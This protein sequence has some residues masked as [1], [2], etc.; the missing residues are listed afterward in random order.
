MAGE[1]ITKGLPEGAARRA[2]R[3]LRVGAS[4]DFDFVVGRRLPLRG[5]GR[6]EP[7]AIGRRLRLSFEELGPNFVELGRFVS[8]RGDLLPPGVV[9]ELR[10]ARP[11]V[12]PLTPESVRGVVEEEL[13]GPLER[14][15]PEFEETPVRSG[16]ATQSHRA[17]L[18]GDRPALVVVDRPGLR[19]DLLAMRPVADVA[20]RRLGERLPLDPTGIVADFAAHMNH[21]RDM[22]AAAQNARRLRELEGTGLRVPRSYR[23]YSTERVITFERPGV[24]AP[25]GGG[26]PEAG[27]ALIRLALLE[28]YSLADLVPERI[29]VDADGVLWLADPTEMLTL[30][31]ERMRGVAEVLASARRGDADG[32]IRSL[33]ATGASVPRETSELRRSLRGVLGSLGGPLWAENT[34]AETR[35][36]SLEACR[37]GGV[38]LSGEV[39]LMADSLVQAEALQRDPPAGDQ[40]TGGERTGITA[41]AGAADDLV[42]R[43]RDPAYVASRTARGLAQ[44]DAYADYP[45]QLHSLLNELKDGE[46]EVRFQHRG[47]NELISK[48]D[49]LAN[50]LVLAL[51]IA[52]LVVGSSLLGVFNQSGL[53]LLGVNIFGL[54]GFV[55]AAVLG[56]ALIVG[57]IRSGRL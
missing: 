47:I 37:L 34:L 1:R 17:V 48:V 14:L 18:P 53:V 29:A 30:D 40:P 32:V 22:Y 20:R 28:G 19:P 25:D 4:Y 16:V 12:E 49:I 6:M 3:I 55:F 42:S 43:Y 45:R 24:A 57:I 15:F 26:Y 41:A 11:V 9:G 5:R 46:I 54:V 2:A 7:E 56:L 10:R 39:A 23:D 21:R 13:G 44:P 33:P 31:P 27:R 8:A 36:R 52:A 38:R 51:L 50:R 35:D